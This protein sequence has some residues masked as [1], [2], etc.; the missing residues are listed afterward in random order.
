MDSLAVNALNDIAAL[1]PGTVSGRTRLNAIDYNSVVGS[2]TPQQRGVGLSLKL[3]S[4]GASFN[5]PVGDDSVIDLARRIGRNGK[6]YSVIT[7]PP[8]GDRGIDANNLCCQIHQRSAAIAGI[9]G[10]IGLKESLELT[11]GPAFNIP[12]LCTHNSSCHCGIESEWAADCEYPI[13]HFH[14]IGIAKFGRFEGPPNI[15]F[16]NRKICPLIKTDHAGLVFSVIAPK[17]NGYAINVLSFSAVFIRAFR[18]HVLVGKNVSIF[19]E[20]DSRAQTLLAE[21]SATPRIS[22]KKLIQKIVQGGAIRGMLFPAADTNCRFGIDIDDGVFH[23][24]G[25]LGESGGK[26][27][28]RGYRE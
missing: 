16:D 8:G 22:L 24:V 13:A 19:I 11:L 3:H 2:E 27:S 1:Q 5:R 28:R 26:V 12:S 15:D 14:R 4:D 21:I 6:S 17:G 23:L 20:D 10:G 9:N 25:N 7:S 18:N